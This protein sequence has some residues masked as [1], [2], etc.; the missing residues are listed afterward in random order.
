MFPAQLTMTT[1]GCPIAYLYQQY[2]IDF[3]TGTTLDNLYNCTQVS[4][5]IR[6]GK[7]ET[8]WTFMFSDGYGKFTGAP[9]L[10]KIRQG[11]AAGIVQAAIDAQ[12]KAPKAAPKGDDKKSDSGKK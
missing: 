1:F 5:T 11:V 7:F 10:T 2:F 3:G 6:A 9:T 12:K 4:H 8:N